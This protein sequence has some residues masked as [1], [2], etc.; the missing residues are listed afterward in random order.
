MPLF[1]HRGLKCPTRYWLRRLSDPIKQCWFLLLTFSLAGTMGCK[2]GPDFHIPKAPPLS[3]E[4]AEA[5]PTESA[6]FEELT[7]WWAGLN[8]PVLNSLIA[9][10]CRQ[11]L[12]LREAYFRVAVARAELGVVR[13][14]RL[15]Q[16]DA[17]AGYAWRDFSE[18]ASQFVS[19]SAG[20]RGFSFHRLGFDTRWEIDLFGKI[21][22]GI[23]SAQATLDASVETYRDVK[24]T[25]LAEVA[26][27]YVELRLAQ[28]RLRIAERNLA[29]QRDTLRI[30]RERRESGLVSPLDVAQAESNV[31]QTAATIPELRQ[32]ER[33]ALNQLAVLLARTPDAAFIE[34]LAPG[35]SP[36]LP[37]YL[38]VW[39]EFPERIHVKYI[40]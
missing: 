17:V 24:V 3:S 30:V 22:R 21:A 40:P 36:Q 33:I 39:L 14:D 10:A 12:D 16:A 28:E 35:T 8:D 38:G 9:E 26:T 4:Y 1:S 31:Y 23:E 13:A 11:N 15:P 20:N 37:E 27:S 7:Y 29:A 19:T 32:L 18:N 2:V 6:T 25:L 34:R 5:K